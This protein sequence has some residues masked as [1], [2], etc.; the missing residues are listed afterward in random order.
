[1]TMR[2]SP[3][4]RRKHILQ[5][6]KRRSSGYLLILSFWRKWALGAPANRVAL[7]WEKFPNWKWLKMAFEKKNAYVPVFR[8]EMLVKEYVLSS[9]RHLITRLI[10]IFAFDS[11]SLSIAGGWRKCGT[12]LIFLSNCSTRVSLAAPGIT[13]SPSKRICRGT[14]SQKT[15]NWPTCK[16]VQVHSTWTQPRG[17]GTSFRPTLLTTWLSRRLASEARRLDAHIHG[18]LGST[19]SPLTKKHIPRRP[20]CSLN[21]RSGATVPSRESE[22]VRSSSFINKNHGEVND[23]YHASKYWLFCNICKIIFKSSCQ[24]PLPTAVC[25]AAQTDWL[26]SPIVQDPGLPIRRR[27]QR[28]RSQERLRRDAS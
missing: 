2:I 12:I 23:W 21:R 3:T 27:S 5:R 25:F 16:P 24:F 6:V 4:F 18:K 15:W 10:Y 28:S 9:S 11:G 17:G 19:L 20:C 14:L 7:V 8:A 13:R 1:M 22:L 26:A